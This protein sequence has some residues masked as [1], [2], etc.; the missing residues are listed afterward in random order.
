MNFSNKI[1]PLLQKAIRILPS[2]RLNSSYEDLFHELF[3]RF[4]IDQNVIFGKE[5]SQIFNFF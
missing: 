3:K 4:S 5:F 1:I 2:D